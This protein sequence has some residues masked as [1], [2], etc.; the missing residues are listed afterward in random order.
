MITKMTLFCK[1]KKKRPQSEHTA[2]NPRGSASFCRILFLI[3]SRAHQTKHN[4][5]NFRFI[6]SNAVPHLSGNYEQ[7]FRP[8]NLFALTKEITYWKPNL[9]CIEKKKKKKIGEPP[10]RCNSLI[11]K[12]SKLLAGVWTSAV[13]RERCR[14]SKCTMFK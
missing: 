3:T 1:K 6:Y 5:S 4:Y 10:F 2:A 11:L 8:G 7:F 14:I 9:L 12:F 13:N